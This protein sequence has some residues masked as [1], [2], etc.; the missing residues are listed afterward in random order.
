[1]Y[2]LWRHA[3]PGRGVQYA[4]AL[5][6]LAGWISLVVA[7]LSPLHPLGNLLFAAH[8]TQHEILML[9][10]APLLVLGRPLL[11][12]LWALPLAWRKGIATIARPATV[13]R[14]WALLT[15]PLAAW[16][17]HLVALWLWH[18][19]LLFE[20][21]LRSDLIHTAQHV[22][23]LGSA[24][25]FW[26]AI[27]H[28]GRR[29]TLYGV[30]LL[31]LFTTALHS[32]TLG[33]LLTFSRYAWYESYAATAPPLGLTALED[34]QLGGLIM[35]IPAGFIY[36]FAALLLAV[37]WIHP[38]G[39]ATESTLGRREPARGVALRPVLL[40]ACTTLTLSAC[41]GRHEERGV[42]SG[43][44][45]RGRSLMVHYG[46]ASCH[47]ISGVPEARGKIGPPLDGIAE[48]M[49]IGGVLENTP[50]NL[51][52]WIR[53]PQEASPRTAMPPTGTSD[54][55]T[56]DIVAFLYTLR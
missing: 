25:L 20:A 50:E 22:S 12:T 14:A 32:G 17:V 4:E 21:T 24:L 43:N 36:L 16:V 9:V 41:G 49:Y 34:Q 19:P 47:E 10:S 27:L 13:R 48:R 29:T 45:E 44:I 3:A 2:R 35:W 54:E 39:W 53:N 40:I 11:P 28:T 55:D 5:C 18:I 31:C 38:E 26:W 42:L 30:G 8:M 46:C 37:C 23:F 7:L 33:A 1:M 56:R 52:R 15:T 51:F 6:F